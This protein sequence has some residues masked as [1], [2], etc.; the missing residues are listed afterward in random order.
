MTLKVLQIAIDEIGYLEKETNSQLDDKTANAGRNNYTKYARD[1]DNL[2]NFYNGKKNGYPWC[3]IFVDWCFFKAYG[4]QWTQT[5]LNQPNKSAG[6][7]CTYSLRYFKK[8]GRFYTSN[9]KPGDQIFFGKIEDSTHTGLVE[10]VDDIYVYTIEGN[11]SDTEGVIP[12]G[13]AV[14]R[15]KYKLNSS[16]IAGYGRPNYSLVR[17]DG[18]LEGEEE[19]TQEQFNEMMNVYLSNLAKEE[20]SAWSAESRAFCEQAG[21]IK[22][23]DFGNKMYKKFLTREEAA[24]L[25]YRLFHAIK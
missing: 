25:L 3:D 14:C 17:D 9:P 8:M 2:E 5:L 1:L 20:P 22:G 7:G 4:R 16:Y 13:G 23:D 6:A 19:V 18:N 12:N 11:T 10:K 21:L 24:A 15:K